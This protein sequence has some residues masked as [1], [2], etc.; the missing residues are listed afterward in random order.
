MPADAT[1]EEPVEPAE[2]IEHRGRPRGTSARALELIA[3]ELFSANGF[4]E[5][6]VDEIA[7]AAG[8]SRRT[9]FRYFET[10][11][12]V[13]WHGFDSEVDALR[14][15][16]AELPADLPVMQAVRLAVQHVNEVRS[17]NAVELRVRMGLVGSV[18][19]LQASATRHYDAWEQVVIDDAAKRLGLPADSLM[20]RAIGR[21]TLAACRAAYEQWMQ[22]PGTDLLTHIDA[23]LGALGGGF[24]QSPATPVTG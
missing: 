10:K 24:G 18:P 12:D 3:L 17:G 20:P 9:F 19:A 16:F 22:E 2:P 14:A 21:T 1:L 7:V 5:T 8:V 15:A 13:L 6:T 4:D 23:V 11:T